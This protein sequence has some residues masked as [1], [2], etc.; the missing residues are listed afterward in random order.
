MTV[1]FPE[2][3]FTDRAAAEFAVT[4]LSTPEGLRIARYKPEPSYEGKT[5]AD[6]AELT[7][8]SPAD[9]LM[10][11]IADAEDLR[12]E[13]VRDVESVIATS[14]HEDDIEKLMAWRHTNIATDGSLDGAHPRGY[15]TYPR[16]L[17]RYVRERN[18]LELSEAVRRM[19]SLAAEHMGIADR[20]RIDP[21]FKADLVMFDSETILDHATPADPQALSTGVAKVWVN[22]EIVYQNGTLTG[23]RPGRVLRR[24]EGEVER[25]AGG[26]R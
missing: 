19:T 18:V 22:G 23:A 21:G 2:R 9:A 7:G 25:M 4:Q 15:G 3:D 17:S 14:M 8:R 20:G 10:Q 1:M 11:L 24:G 13:G 12:A 5:L 16:V 6:V 26:S